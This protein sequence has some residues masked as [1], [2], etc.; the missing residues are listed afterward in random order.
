MRAKED[1]LRPTRIER[2]RWHPPVAADVAAPKRHARQSNREA[3]ANRAGE[4]VP[5][6]RRVARP[7]DRIALAAR[8]A[9]T[10]PYEAVAFFLAHDVGDRRVIEEGIEVVHRLPR[11]PIAENG[12]RRHVLAEI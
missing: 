6:R 12:V 2:R 5:I 1:E 4:A 3:A 11:F 7:A 9:R 8:R 10:P